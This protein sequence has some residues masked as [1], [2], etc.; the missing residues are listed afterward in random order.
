M[1]VNAKL[2]Y[3]ITYFAYFVLYYSLNIYL[4]TS[5][6]ENNNM[7]SD[8]QQIIHIC[9]MKMY[10][11]QSCIRLSIINCT[12]QHKFVLILRLPRKL[13]QD[14]GFLIDNYRIILI[15]N[16]N[17]MFPNGGAQNKFY[18]NIELYHII[19]CECV[20]Q[21]VY[22]SSVMIRAIS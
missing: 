5:Q 7:T 19:K 17:V 12:C 4:F 14:L 6:F 11:T 3:N 20:T 13:H 10:I 8:L 1:S 2:Y 22:I 18:G 21:T 16:Y 9:L 15:L